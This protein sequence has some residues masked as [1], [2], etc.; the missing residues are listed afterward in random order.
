MFWNHF[1]Q[2][3][4]CTGRGKR[5]PDFRRSFPEKPDADRAK[6]GKIGKDGV[7]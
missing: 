6:I 7:L 3:E 2:T 1:P 4:G 5:L